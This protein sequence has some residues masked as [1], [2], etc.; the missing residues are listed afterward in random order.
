MVNPLRKRITSKSHELFPDGG[1]YHI[2]NSPLICS[3]KQWTCFYMISTSVMKKLTIFG[4][5]S[6]IDVWQDPKCVSSEVV[7]RYSVKKVFLKMLQNL[8]ENTSNR[9]FFSIKLL[10]YQITILLKKRLWH[11]C[12]P[13]NF[14]KFLN[15]PSLQNTSGGCFCPAAW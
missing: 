7:W 9:V 4:K 3:A 1:P 12:F 14:R 10:L 15:K 5:S 13:V 8:Q 11:L 2:E 6:T